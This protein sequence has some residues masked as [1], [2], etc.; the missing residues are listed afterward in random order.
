M[1]CDPT[2]RVDVVKVAWPLP[3]TD[4]VPKV[5]VPFLNVTVPVGT[6]LPGGV[7]VTVAV[8]VTGWLKTDGLAEELT[9]VV[10]AD[11]FTA[12][13]AALSLP[14]LLPQPLAPVNTA[15]TVWLA[16]ASAVVLHCAGAVL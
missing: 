3:S 9:V 15:V 10:V 7:A 12:W 5:E 13:G 16:A 11:L 2:V 4:P 1:E 14:L 8:K 6:P